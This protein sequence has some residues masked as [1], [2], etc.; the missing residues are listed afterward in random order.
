MNYER[1]QRRGL[2]RV[3][4][5]IMLKCLGVNIRRLLDSFEDNKFKH[6]CWNVPDDLHKETFPYVK[7]K[8]ETVKKSI[9]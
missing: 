5:E 9:T 8:K 4:C 1:I 2:E 6:N 3:S 7:Q